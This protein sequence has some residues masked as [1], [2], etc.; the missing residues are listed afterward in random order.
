M[1]QVKKSWGPALFPL[2]LVLLTAGC[3]EVQSV[4]TIGE[5][6]SRDVVLVTVAGLGTA[7]ETAGLASFERLAQRCTQEHRVA[8]SSEP[9]A[10]LT[11]LFTGLLPTQWYG[12]QGAFAYIG[13][14]PGLERAGWHLSA[15]STGQATALCT[16]RQSL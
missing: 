1:L 7:T 8:A 6:A 14:V 12:L 5:T 13:L 15:L 3:G 4:E 10:S 11:S 16:A 2:L 9:N